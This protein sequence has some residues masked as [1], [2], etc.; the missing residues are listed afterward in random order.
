MDNRAVPGKLDEL[1]RAFELIGF[2]L[3]VQSEAV[4]EELLLP[5]CVKLADRAELLVGNGVERDE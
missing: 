2:K 1:A 4:V 5:T 3:G